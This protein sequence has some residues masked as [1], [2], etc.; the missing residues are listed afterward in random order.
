MMPPPV[1]PV[2]EAQALTRD[3]A[4][5]GATVHALRG[6]DLAVT[7]GEMVAV[8]G[9]SG[10][11]KTTLLNL[12]GG[13]DRPT[14]GRVVLLGDREVSSMTE[15]GLVDLRRHEVAYIFQTFG[16]LPYLSAAENVEI[17]LRLRRE[18]PRERDRR[19]LELLDLVGLAGRARHRPLEMSGG[20][21]QR[22]AI[23]RALAGDPKLLLADEPTGQLDSETALRIVLLLRD[24]MRW[25]DLTI[26]VATHDPQLLDVADRV[27]ELRDGRF[28]DAA[29]YEPVSRHSRPGAAPQ[30]GAG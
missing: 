19:V 29:R 27:K 12:L 23:A 9:R 17:P 30:P 10:S 20:E 22:V 3:F 24:V 13:I 7:P 8:A 28:T 1:I 4:F 15:D 6:V 2:V 25:R 26:V 5:G 14:S 16:L 21:Q 11:G 18:E